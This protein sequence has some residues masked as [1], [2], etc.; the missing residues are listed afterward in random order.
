MFQ[1]RVKQSSQGIEKNS[2]K[3]KKSLDKL[4]KVGYNN[5][6]RN[7]EKNK[8]KKEVLTMTKMTYAQALEIAIA[9]VDGEAKEKLEALKASIEKRNSADRKPTKA[10][11]ANEGLK[12]A[13]VDLLADGKARTITEIANEIEALEG[14]SPQ[15]ISALL[16][17][18]KKANVVVREEIKRKAYF[19]VA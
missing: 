13:I 11:V 9:K 18:L 12:D 10:Q 17:Q 14:A 19:K 8:L 7:K 5:N 3:N 2:K 16:T 15:K 1:E 6:V 4:K